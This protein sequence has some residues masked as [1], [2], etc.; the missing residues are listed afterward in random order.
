M[1]PDNYK[2]LPLE[3]AK[4]V[5]IAAEVHEK[6]LIAKRDAEGISMEEFVAVREELKAHRETAKALNEMIAAV[7]APDEQEVAPVETPAEVPE[8]E[9]VE[10]KVK[11]EA[12]VETE[13]P[14]AEVEEVSTET[15]AAE[16]V[17]PEM[18]VSAETVAEIEDAGAD[19]EEI[20]PLEAVAASLT[21]GDIVDNINEPSETT[22]P[23][24]THL[25]ASFV[26]VVDG[27][28]DELEA[29]AK[30]KARPAGGEAFKT[31]YSGDAVINTDD[32]NAGQLTDHIMSLGTPGR[33][34]ELTRGQ[35]QW[36]LNQKGLTGD[37]AAAICQPPQLLDSDVSCGSYDPAIFNLFPNFVMEGLEL[38]VYVPVDSSDPDF[39][40]EVPLYSS[41]G[42]PITTLAEKACYELECLTR[43]Q[44]PVK[45][46]KACLTANEQTA[47]TSPRSVQGLLSDGRALL[48]A[49]RDQILLD[50]II[51][52]T[53]KF[54]YTAGTA[55]YAEVPLAM[56]QV[57]EDLNRQSVITQVDDLV[58]LVP[59]SFL[60]YA[61]ADQQLKAFSDGRADARTAAL[62]LFT[63]IGIR[64]VVVYDDALDSTNGAAVPS[65]SKTAS[66]AIGTASARDDWSIHLI[67]P[68]DGFV[69]L[70]N[71]NEYSLEPVA[72]SITELRNNRLSW[73]ARN[74]FTPGRR[75]CDGWATI[76]VANLCLGG[77]VVAAASCMGA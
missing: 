52:E 49:E 41:S 7:E 12:V 77:R 17:A 74:Y 14:V 59:Y 24:V 27:A 37:V 56:T 28:Q 66:T 16:V 48:A 46:V 47:F 63:S 10:D 72:Q 50:W 29:I 43:V 61:V 11:E 73:F 5:A 54:G 30:V 15:P 2:D 25:A 35:K 34:G 3:E 58:A 21:T 60:N 39:V 67:N 55:G 71:E 65:L 45:E 70:R 32:M 40:G 38:E 53:Y 75:G 64:D 36:A 42:D 57:I 51:D 31:V 23:A 76:N 1:I 13:V 9:K 62:D 6:S 4:K 68:A 18:E 22:A 44:F 19:V 20:K 69:G 8:E 33:E 26:T